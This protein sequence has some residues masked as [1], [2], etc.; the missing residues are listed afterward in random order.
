M[1]NNITYESDPFWVFKNISNSQYN[2]IN[3]IENSQLKDILDISEAVQILG[4]KMIASFLSQHLMKLIN[5][6]YSKSIVYECLDYCRKIKLDKKSIIEEVVFDLILISYSQEM[7]IA[8]G[9]EENSGM[10]SWI[11]GSWQA[12]NGKKII[13]GDHNLLNLYCCVVAE[14]MKVYKNV[15]IIIAKRVFAFLMNCN[16]PYRYIDDVSCRKLLQEYIKD[17]H[18]LYEEVQA[19]PTHPFSGTSIV[20]LL[21]DENKY[22]YLSDYFEDRYDGYILLSNLGKKLKRFAKKKY[23]LPFGNNLIYEN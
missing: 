19:Y 10:S 17:K 4:P 2:G 12:I 3:K 7:V 13:E 9:K 23:S 20:D 5:E 18:T 14:N 21:K 11:K 8:R 1:D 22:N 6:M 15:P 16:N